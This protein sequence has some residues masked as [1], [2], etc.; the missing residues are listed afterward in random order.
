[1]LLSRE[2]S[3]TMSVMSNMLGSSCNARDYTSSL[4]EVITL[5]MSMQRRL[6]LFKYL[7][8]V[9][10]ILPVLDSFP[11]NRCHRDATSGKWECGL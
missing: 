2:V 4:K 5:T 1:M 8:N 11:H 3:I 9:P 7:L 10:K 6:C